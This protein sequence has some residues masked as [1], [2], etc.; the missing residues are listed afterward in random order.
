MEHIMAD[1]TRGTG[2]DSPEDILDEPALASVGID[3]DSVVVAPDNTPAIDE[4]DDDDRFDDDD[5]E[6]D[7]DD[8]DED[9]GQKASNEEEDKE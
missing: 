5:D 1:T 8:D 2:A 9:D 7:E 4:E 6:D 3:P